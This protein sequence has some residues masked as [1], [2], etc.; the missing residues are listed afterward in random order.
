MSYVTQ[1]SIRE[2]AG[3]LKR[4]TGETPSGL[5][6]GTNKAY[7]TKRGPLVDSN[8][9]GEVTAEDVV[10]YVAGVA[11]A[12]TSV[13]APTHTI[14][15]AAAP[16]NGSK[17]TVDYFFSPLTDDYVD[18]KVAEADSWVDL[19]LKSSEAYQLGYITLPIEPTPGV[20]S[21]A[22]EMYAAGL[23]LTRDY[24]SSPDTSLT[25]KDGY[26]KLKTAR[27][28]ILDYIGGALVAGRTSSQGSKNAVTV[29]TNRDVF[30]REH[31]E[32]VIYADDDEWFMRR[33]VD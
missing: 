26:Q 1:Q 12:V 15:L 8:N 25:S 33:Q 22:A 2:N 19:K 11:V 6:N 9:D 17:V 27:E 24:G 16:A 20:L 30:N 10:A 28:L 29:I 18:G 31:Y 3:M 13:D 7:T 4:V 23:I 32:N 14:T 21:T 5:V